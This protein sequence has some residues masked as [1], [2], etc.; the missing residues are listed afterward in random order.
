MA[1]T[2]KSYG[3][4]QVWTGYSWMSDFKQGD[5][6]QKNNVNPDS[7]ALWRLNEKGI[8]AVRKQSK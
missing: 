2:A 5:S 6:I 7:I 1:Y 8:A 3:H 4:I